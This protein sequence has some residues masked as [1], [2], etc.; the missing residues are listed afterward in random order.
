[1]GIVSF[2]ACLL[3]ALS[4]CFSDAFVVDNEGFFYAVRGVIFSGNSRL[5][6][7]NL[8]FDM[9]YSISLR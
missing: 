8:F 5:R 9:L 6:I 3:G 2:E 1:M 7:K 4:T